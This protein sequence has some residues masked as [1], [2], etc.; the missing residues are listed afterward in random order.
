MKNRVISYLI[1]ILVL[2]SL[3]A[4]DK[5]SAFQGTAESTAPALSEKANET[6]REH[7]EDESIHL[8]DIVDRTRL[9]MIATAD[10]LEEFYND[11][12]YTYYLPSIMSEHI[13]CTFAF[14]CMSPP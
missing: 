4:C 7:S 1:G 10:A 13:E 11:D 6:K 14:V 2:L 9:E 8:T 5:P 3:T 12:T